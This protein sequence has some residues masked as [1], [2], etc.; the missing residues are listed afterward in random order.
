M[1]NPPSYLELWLA[2]ENLSLPQPQIWVGIDDNFGIIIL[3]FHLNICCDP[4]LEPSDRDGSN[5]GQNICF[6]GNL[7]GIIPS[8]HQLPLI[9]RTS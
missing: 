7:T 9:C 2:G 5:V 1:L 6:H 8:Y 3:I 4:S